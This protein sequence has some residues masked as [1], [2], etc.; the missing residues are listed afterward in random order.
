MRWLAVSRR[1][2]AAAVDRHPSGTRNWLLPVLLVPHCDEG[3]I[4]GELL[5]R[6]LLVSA[7]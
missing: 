1:D 3:A 2:V 6:L 5:M 7:T 4:G